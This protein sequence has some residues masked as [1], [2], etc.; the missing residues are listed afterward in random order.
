MVECDAA[1]RNPAIFAFAAVSTG[2][3]V[4][5]LDG[6]SGRV[7]GESPG[8]L[9]RIVGLLLTSLV[10]MGFTGVIAL[11]VVNGETQLLT[12]SVLPALLLHTVS[13]SIAAP[14]FRI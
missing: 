8:Q 13:N 4:H 5:W 6:V 7:P 2:W 14:F 10:L 3:I 9:L 11:S 1:I 12:R